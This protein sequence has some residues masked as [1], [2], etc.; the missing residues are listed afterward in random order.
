MLRNDTGCGTVDEAVAS[1]NR[2]PWFESSQRQ[3]LFIANCVQN[4]ENKQK[5]D[6]EGFH[7]KTTLRKKLRSKGH[8][9]FVFV[10]A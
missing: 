8:C 4:N 7:F 3:N 6:R 1:D 10:H 9:K 5:W 2:D